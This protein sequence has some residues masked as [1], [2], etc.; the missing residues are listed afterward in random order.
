[1][2]AVEHSDGRPNSCY[3]HTRRTI[4]PDKTPR[5]ALRLSINKVLMQRI[6]NLKNCTFIRKLF[7]C[8]Y[9]SPHHISTDKTSYEFEFAVCQWNTHM[10]IVRFALWY[11]HEMTITC[12]DYGMRTRLSVNLCTYSQKYMHIENTRARIYHCRFFWLPQVYY[13]FVLL[14]VRNI[15]Q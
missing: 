9:T 2:H 14:C 15:P 12:M 8:C 1:M 13:Y 5:N 11:N 4:I 10:P 6:D 3:N 7:Q